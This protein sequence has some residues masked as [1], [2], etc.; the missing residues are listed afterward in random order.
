MGLSSLCVQKPCRGF[1]CTLQFES[2]CPDVDIANG[3]GVLLGCLETG[4]VWS[5]QKG[6]NEVCRIAQVEATK[7]EVLP[8]WSS[9][10]CVL[11]LGSRAGGWQPVWLGSDRDPGSHRVLSFPFPS[12]FLPRKKWDCWTCEERGLKSRFQLALRQ[13]WTLWEIPSFLWASVSSSM[14][15]IPPAKHGMVYMPHS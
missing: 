15:P 1:C 10:L 14:E 9:R 12:S 7:Q 8:V 3:W 2:L 5:S 6:I 11:F 4:K 13:L